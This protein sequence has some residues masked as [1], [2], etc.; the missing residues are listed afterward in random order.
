MGDTLIIFDCDGVLVDSEVLFNRV[1]ADQL[2]ACGY[3]ID[4]DSAIERF[5]GMSM[6]SLMA[7]VESD[8]GHALPDGHPT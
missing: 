7:V 5:T 1:L 6:P 8:L 3:P 2:T 4:A